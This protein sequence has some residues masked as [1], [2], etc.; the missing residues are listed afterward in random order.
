MLIGLA[1]K[2][3]VGT[4]HFRNM[5]RKSVTDGFSKML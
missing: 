3:T 5:I 1:K 4:I 2:I